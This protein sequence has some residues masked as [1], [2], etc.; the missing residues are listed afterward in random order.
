[1]SHHQISATDLYRLTQSQKELIILDVRT[2]EE[3]KAARIPHSYNL[4][5]DQVTVERV[6]SLLKER[7]QSVDTPIYITC[8]SGPRA[9]RACEILEKN[10][11]NV[12]H[13]VG[14]VNGWMHENLPVEKG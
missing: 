12:I 6:T 5:I 3:Y 1:M 10:F 8:A 9:I 11:K 7:D 13:I 4:P 14:C 2:P